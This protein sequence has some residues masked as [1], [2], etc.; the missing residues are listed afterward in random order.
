MNSH[1]YEHGYIVVTK[2]FKHRSIDIN[3]GIA[4]FRELIT[5]LLYNV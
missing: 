1:I 5:I 3:L 4:V 2:L